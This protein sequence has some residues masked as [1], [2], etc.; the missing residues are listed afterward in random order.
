MSL[1]ARIRSFLTGRPVPDAVFQISASA[2]S[3]IRRPGRD[4][5]IKRGFVLPFEVSPIAPSFDQ[6]N[7]RDAE[8][9]SEAL[10]QGKQALR[11]GS[12]SVAILLPEAAVR[13][14]V[15]PAED[16]PR[17][18]AEQ[19]AF[20]RW[21]IGRQIPV[22]PED[23]RLSYVFQPGGEPR[24]ILVALA[25]ATVVREYEALFE[26]AGLRPA[27]V[28]VPSLALANLAARSARNGLLLN[29]EGDTVTLL[30]SVGPAWVLH[31][32]KNIGPGGRGPDEER[33][34]T[35]VR[36]TENTLRFLEDKE[37]ARV[38]TLW[39]RSA[40][41]SETSEILSRLKRRTG[42][43]VAILEGAGPAVWGPSHRALL[44]PLFGEMP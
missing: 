38:E 37:K 5:A 25:R 6:P 44:A 10:A 42:L 3:G 36:E 29:V 13:V 39:L 34:E 2:L 9:V 27:L 41:A 14:I 21:R 33:I 22:L 40:A 12:G 26:R 16:F 35:I 24:R 11:L 32:Q 28:S 18:E 23:V 31:R 19:E 43:E 17:L 4:G 7:V 20:I 30:A 8:A 1:G 15:L